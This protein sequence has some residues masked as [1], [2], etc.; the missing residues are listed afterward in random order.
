MTVH[1]WFI[2]TFANIEESTSAD[3]AEDE[4]P[5]VLVAFDPGIR[6]TCSSKSDHALA[7]CTR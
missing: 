1:P 3:E 2:G 5:E 7:R 6:H 4:A